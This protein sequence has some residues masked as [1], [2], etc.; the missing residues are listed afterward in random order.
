[1]QLGFESSGVIGHHQSSGPKQVSSKS[2]R[3][4][5]TGVVDGGS[6]SRGLP[7]T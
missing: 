6:G 2:V 3:L 1:M 5:C 4:A 7:R